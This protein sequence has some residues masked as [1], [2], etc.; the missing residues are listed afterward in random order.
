[1]EKSAF[2]LL[3]SGIFTVVLAD[4]DAHPAQ[5]AAELLAVYGRRVALFRYK[6]NRAQ[7]L[8][9]LLQGQEGVVDE[10]QRRLLQARLDL[11]MDNC[12]DI[13]DS[14]DRLEDWFQA[15]ITSLPEGSTQKVQALDPEGQFDQVQ[16]LA[17][18]MDGE[19][20][21]AITASDPVP[22]AKAL[23]EQRMS[24]AQQLFDEAFA[25]MHRAIAGLE[26]PHEAVVLEPQADAV[27]S[28]AIAIKT[29]G[30]QEVRRTCQ[31]HRDGK[32]ALAQVSMVAEKPWDQEG[33]NVKVEQTKRAPDGQVQTSIQQGTTKDLQGL[34]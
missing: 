30:R 11:V 5:S 12:R 17:P 31:V 9:G 14:L 23:A 18:S 6:V 32:T 27:P 20:V 24:A 4:Y 28:P 26:T 34:S 16:D 21:P 3:F 7:Q 19:T 8:Q 10:E 13:R 2:L 25:K 22:T 33:W 29:T 15:A 1:V